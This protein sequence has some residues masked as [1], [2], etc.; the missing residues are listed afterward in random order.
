[1]YLDFRESF[2]KIP[3][4]NFKELAGVSL[5]KWREG[6]DLSRHISRVC[7]GGRS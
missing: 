1:M 6:K 3:K 2:L 5:M 7:V 4:L